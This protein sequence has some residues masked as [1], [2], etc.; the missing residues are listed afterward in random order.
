[1]DSGLWCR[2]ISAGPADSPPHGR[3]WWPPDSASALDQISDTE[4]VDRGVQTISPFL[5]LVQGLMWAIQAKAGT[6]YNLVLL[7]PDDLPKDV[8]LD[9]LGSVAEM[10]GCFGGWDPIPDTCSWTRWT[11]SDKWKLMHRSPL[12]SWTN[13]GGHLCLDWRPMSPHW[14]PF[15]CKA[16]PSIE[17]GGVPG[18][19]EV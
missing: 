13:E 1:M 12:D 10:R 14:L 8:A 15:K 18:C 11:P 9:R 7:C 19:L 4:P 5:G 3:P 6:M 17:D 16:Q 2:E